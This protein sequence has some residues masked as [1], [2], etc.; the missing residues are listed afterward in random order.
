[1]SLKWFHLIF[2]GTSIVLTVGVAAWAVQNAQ[3]LLAVC[4]LAAGGVLVV[5]RGAFLRKMAAAGLR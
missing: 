5:Y 3:W 2:I 4:A 1:M